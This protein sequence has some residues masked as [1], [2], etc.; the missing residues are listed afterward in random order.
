M[1]KNILATSVFVWCVLAFTSYSYS[2]LE[3][4][5]PELTKEDVQEA[6]KYGADN[7]D[8]DYVEF[9]KDWRL[10]LGY[11]TGSARV[12]TPFSKIAFE[13]KQAAAEGEPVDKD[14]VEGIIEGS[15]GKLA[16][17]MAIYGDSKAFAQEAVA[18]IEQDGKTIEPI[19]SRPAMK[20]EPTDFWPNAPAYKAICYYYFPMDKLDPDGKVTV[21]V[22]IPDQRGA[23]FEF[24]LSGMR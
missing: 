15:K 8:V 5:I 11:G 2:S 23:R 7:K 16:I 9:F 6:V 1:N 20:A 21:V 3:A 19:E 22:S 17:G 18:V 13:A 10:D 12:I 14:V 24:D 4:V